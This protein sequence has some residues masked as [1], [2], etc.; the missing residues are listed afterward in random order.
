MSIT[1]V[2]PYVRFGQNGPMGDSRSAWG[3]RI[4]Q[5]R[6]ERE[7]SMDQLAD[8]V[9][10]VTT[11]SKISKL[12]K[13]KTKIT[14]EWLRRIADALE[15]DILDIVAPMAR[16]L[17]SEAAQFLDVYVELEEEHQE[18]VFRVANSLPRKPPAP[19]RR[20]RG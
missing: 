12:E 16:R 15:V 11:G 5:L 9:V 10:P 14:E 2:A 18:T 4:K 20:R 3:E 17:G 7:W 6:E 13:G 1:T 19:S 8:R